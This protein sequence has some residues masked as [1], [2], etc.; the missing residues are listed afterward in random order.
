MHLRCIAG[1]DNFFSILTPFSDLLT[2]T[3][4]LGSKNTIALRQANSVSSILIFFNG[5][6]SSSITLTPTLLISKS[7]WL[8]PSVK[9]NGITDR[10]RLC[11]SYLLVIVETE[12][13][14]KQKHFANQ[15]ISHFSGMHFRIAHNINP[16][17]SQTIYTPKS[18]TH[19]T[20]RPVT[21]CKFSF[22]DFISVYYCETLKWYKYNIFDID[23]NSS[24]FFD[25][26]YYENFVTERVVLSC[27]SQILLLR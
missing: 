13:G 4:L 18:C 24:I 21:N 16:G 23:L 3:H 7:C 2:E 5:S 14:E 25:V 20:N 26:K 12:S 27:D 1:N 10:R 19:K 8:L 15:I 9:C 6:T 22:S 17:L 11:H